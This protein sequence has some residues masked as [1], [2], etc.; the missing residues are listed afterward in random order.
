MSQTSEFNRGARRNTRTKLV[1]MVEVGIHQWR[2]GSN[3]L[4]GTKTN[5]GTEETRP[6]RRELGGLVTGDKDQNTHQAHAGYIG[7]TD[8]K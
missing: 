6:M 7:S 3:Q 8:N 2:R 5:I 1:A 4:G